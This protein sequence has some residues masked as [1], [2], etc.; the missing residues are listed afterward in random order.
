[1]AKMFLLPRVLYFFR[2]LPL[3]PAD[4][5]KIQ[6]IFNTF[7]RATRKLQLKSSLLS[8]PTAFA[9]LGAPNIKWYYKAVFR[10]RGFSMAPTGRF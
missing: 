5:A 10:E 4:I 3:L 8:I 7:I 9:S 6:Q 2:T 1:M